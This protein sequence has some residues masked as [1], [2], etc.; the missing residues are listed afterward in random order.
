[1][2]KAP[3]QYVPSPAEIMVA[4]S[5]DKLLELMMTGQL[6]GIGVCAAHKGEREPTFFYL[7]TADKPVLRGPINRLLGLYE[8]GQSFKDLS[9]APPTN[10]SYQVH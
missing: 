10:R 1:M 4:Q 5:I 2:S 7:N 8:A 3:E 6:D 9:N